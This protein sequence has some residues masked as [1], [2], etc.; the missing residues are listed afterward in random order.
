MF[1]GLAYACQLELVYLIIVEQVVEGEG[2]AAL[3]GCRRAEAGAEGNVAG[4][5]G[6][7][8]FDTSAAFDDFAAD[9]KD[10]AC[11]LCLGGV[12]LGQ[13]ELG[14]VV[15]VGRVEAHAVGAVG[16]YVGHD[17]FVDG[18]GEDEAAV[19][20]GVLADEVDAAGRGVEGAFAAKF[21]FKK[22]FEFIFHGGGVRVGAVGEGRRG[23]GCERPRRRRHGLSGGGVDRW[24]GGAGGPAVAGG[25]DYF[26]SCL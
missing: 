13:A 10:V 11:P 25:S 9:A 5:D 19:V 24:P 18:A 6:V 8:A 15:H 23:G 20:V 17:D 21:F 12:L 14:A 7:E 16:A 3:E 4:K 22:G 1:G 2:E 26:T